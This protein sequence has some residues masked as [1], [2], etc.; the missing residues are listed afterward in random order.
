M[1][2]E[3]TADAFPRPPLR[4]VIINGPVTVRDGPGVTFAA[5]GRLAAGTILPVETVDARTGYVRVTARGWI[6][7]SG[8]YVSIESDDEGDS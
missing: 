5:I 1:P 3:V 7:N 4:V 6:T 2:D 8:R